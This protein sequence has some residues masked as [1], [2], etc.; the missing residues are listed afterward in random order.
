MEGL[1][2]L[3][4]LAVIVAT[5]AVSSRKKRATE[6][7]RARDRAGAGEEVRLRGHHGPRRGAAVA[8]PRPGRS[9]SWTPGA[10]ADYQRALDA[11]EAAKTAGD[12]IS[13]A[14][15][16]QARHRDPRGRS[17]RDRLRARPGGRRAAADPASA[18][19][20]RPAPRPLGRGRA[21]HARRVARQRDVPACAL[22]A[23]RVRV[24]AE[25]DIRKVMVGAQRVPY[26]QG[27]R[28]YQPYAAGYFGALRDD[29]RDV[30]GHDVRRLRWLRRHG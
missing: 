27:G 14:G 10:N 5:V 28:A 11:Y 7:E 17:L 19:L 18:V 16:P 13:R 2:L 30:H 1:V 24:G 9:S 3:V 21:V 29:G 23:E 8:R 6:L 20:L 4:L 25:P 15:G 22:D 26:W 12:A